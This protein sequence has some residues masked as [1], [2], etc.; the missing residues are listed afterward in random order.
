M[1]FSLYY[2]GPRSQSPKVF[3]PDKPPVTDTSIFINN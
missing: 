1:M 3:S 2:V